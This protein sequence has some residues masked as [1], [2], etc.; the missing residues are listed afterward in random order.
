MPKRT[1]QEAIAKVVGLD[2]TTVSRILSE[3]P[4]YMSLLPRETIERVQ[5]V[6][7]KMKYDYSQLHKTYR[8]KYERIEVNK[9]TQIEIRIKGEKKI[10]DS[11]RGIIRN[12]SKS[13]ALID[14]LK[15]KGKCFPVYPFTCTFTLEGDKKTGEV[16]RIFP[17]SPMAIGLQSLTTE[18]QEIVEVINN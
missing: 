17:D 5:R 18:K 7:K 8:R 11:G 15:L 13:G 9:P 1:S 3:D 2:R 4:Q 10:F 12:I 16:V 6:A 14:H